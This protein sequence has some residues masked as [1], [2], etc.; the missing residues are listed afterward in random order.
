MLVAKKNNISPPHNNRQLRKFSREEFQS[1]PQAAEPTFN[2][3]LRRI[4]VEEIPESSRRAK[5]FTSSSDPN[6]N[7]IQPLSAEKLSHTEPPQ[8]KSYLS[9]KTEESRHLSVSKTSPQIQ[10]NWLKDR[11]VAA[12]C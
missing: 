3:I 11:A 12:H 7:K 2:R 9:L 1:Q 5:E 6:F 4:A 8:A 10:G